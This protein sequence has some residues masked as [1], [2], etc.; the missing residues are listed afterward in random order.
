[1]V[2]KKKDINRRMAQ[3]V[4]Y[5]FVE[6]NNKAKKEAMEKLDGIS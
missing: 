1:M 3:D 2:E 5:S 4:N 6:K